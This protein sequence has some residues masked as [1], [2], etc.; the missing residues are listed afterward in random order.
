MPHGWAL[1]NYSTPLLYRDF[2]GNIFW[3]DT[4]YSHTTSIIQ[5]KIGR[6]A[7]MLGITM[8]VVGDDREM[9]E[10]ISRETTYEGGF[11][12]VK[13]IEIKQVDPET[14]HIQFETEHTEGLQDKDVSKE[15]LESMNMD[16]L[17]KYLEEG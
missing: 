6:I 9:M 11:S 7:G 15:V 10:E 5:Y 8:D 1:V 12:G 14:Y 17:T 2:E 3:D 4:S 13:I 16:E